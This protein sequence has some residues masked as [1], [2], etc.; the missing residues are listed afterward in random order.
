VKHIHVKADQESIARWFGTE[1]HL[2]S[3]CSNVPT[4]FLSSP[5]L[6]NV[7]IPI[8]LATAGRRPLAA[9]YPA[10]HDRE[11]TTTTDI[12]VLGCRSTRYIAD[13][14]DSLTLSTFALYR[15]PQ[16]SDPNLILSVCLSLP[17]A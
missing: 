8:Y 2:N 7:S 12:L 13:S 3:T 16:P 17:R 1:N 11:T 10:W 14:A 9:R 6:P 4:A 15:Q 5:R